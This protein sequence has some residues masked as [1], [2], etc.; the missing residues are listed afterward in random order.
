MAENASETG[1]A[2]MMNKILLK[3]VK[4]NEEIRKY[5]QGLLDEGSIRESLSMYIVP[6]VL[7]PKKYGE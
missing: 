6:T 1:E 7:T 3:P 4:E 2:L 5:V